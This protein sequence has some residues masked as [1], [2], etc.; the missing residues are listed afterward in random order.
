MSAELM[1]A[2]RAG[3]TPDMAKMQKCQALSEKMGQ[4]YGE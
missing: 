4:M 2:M 3:K 1:E